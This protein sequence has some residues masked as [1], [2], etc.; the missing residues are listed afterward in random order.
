MKRFKLP[1]RAAHIGAWIMP[2]DIVDDICDYWN[3]P[4]NDKFKTDG[5]FGLNG[6]RP[7][8]KESVEIGID[9]N[10]FDKPWDV[11][12]KYL[13][14]CLEDYLSQYPDANEVSAFSIRETYNIQWYPKGGGYKIWHHENPGHPDCSHR[15]LVFMT[16]LNDLPNAGT[17]FKYQNITTPSIKG[18]TL[19][20]PSAFTHTHKGQVTIDHEKMIVTGWYNFNDVFDKFGN[21]T[22]ETYH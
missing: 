14:E 2:H 9:S 3:N 13:Q 20:W 16:Y 22:S 15:H 5:E 6:R 7:N 18:L 8:M 19:I 1:K 17:D 21:A 4:E 10:N 12:R 11:Y